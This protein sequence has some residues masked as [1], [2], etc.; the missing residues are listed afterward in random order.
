VTGRATL[1]VG[2]AVRS[3][4]VRLQGVLRE[5][6]GTPL[7]GRAVS[8]ALETQSQAGDGGA[9]AE[10]TPRA[11]NGS[12]LANSGPAR[13]LLLT[14]PT[15]GICVE[16]G[17]STTRGSVSVEYVDPNGLYVVAPAVV[18]IDPKRVEVSLELTP[19]PSALPL[20]VPSRNFSASVNLRA[21]TDLPTD[22]A[23]LVEL[24]LRDEASATP[25]A[26]DKAIVTAGKATALS[27]ESKDLGSPGPASLILRSRASETLR[28]SERVFP[29]TKTA[30]VN[31][32]LVGSIEPGDATDGIPIRIAA[33]SV[34]GAVDTGTIEATLSGATVGVA[35]VE[36]GSALLVLRFESARDGSVPVSVRYL[37]D[38]PWW[39]SGSKLELEVPVESGGLWRQVPLLI[40]A[41]LLGLWL[42]SAWRRP[43]R[44]QREAPQ[45]E[46]PTGRASLEVLTSGAVGSGWRGVVLDAHDGHPIPH[47]RVLVVGPTFETQGLSVSARTDE[48]GRFELEPPPFELLEGARLEV[49]APWHSSLT[50]PVPEPG[51]LSIHIVARRRTLLNRLVTWARRRGNEWEG[52]LEPTPGHVAQLAR[53]G[54]RAD[55]ARWARDV[56]A[57]AYGPA[58]PYATV[59]NAIENRE[60]R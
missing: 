25:R 55:V 2:A 31:L 1:E 16:F 54:S 29:V 6:T 30:R 15:G 39:T 21:A 35:R 7:G 42:L 26:L 33:G 18:P 58:E 50:R 48:A 12:K 41:G 56:E 20:E 60:P 44:N 5:D 24:L 32:A 23:V 9:T 3:T 57:A 38:A 13:M 59:E 10:G 40:V 36:K 22:G 34:A 19:R 14:S 45:E 4:G 8:I 27:V 37:P 28:A 47:A 51:E 11:C 49:E 17:D 53:R 43:Q 46:L 52:G